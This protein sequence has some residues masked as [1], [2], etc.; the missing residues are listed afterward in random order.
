MPQDPDVRADDGADA[1]VDSV[2]EATEAPEEGSE[3]DAPTH[4]PELGTPGPPF[5]RSP[6]LI[7]FFGALGAFVAWW[8]GSLVLSIG[9]TLVLLVVAMFLAAGLN[10]AVEALEKRHVKRGLAVL[11]VIV[12]VLVAFTGFAFALVPVITDQVTAIG[13][14]VPGWVDQLESNDRIREIND[15]F[16]ILTKVQ[17]FVTGGSF[18]SSIFGGVLGVGIAIFSALA[19]VF[20]VVVLTLYFLASMRATKHAL[21]QLAPASRRDRVSRLGDKVLASVGGYVAG[22]FVVATCAGLSSLIF[23]FVVGLSEYAFALAFVVALLDVIPMVGATLGAVVVTLIG[24]AVD[25]TIG[26]ACLV[27]YLVYQQVENYFIYPRVMSRSVDVPGVVTVIA[28][29]VG[30]ALLGV[31]GALLAIPTASALLM[32][33]REVLIPR[34]DAR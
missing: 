27:F 9:S 16:D 31:V 10:P 25:P 17:D 33:A 2:S 19:N 15:Q 18:I 8:L 14:S 34:Q 20:F 12:G 4:D 1:L 6:F 24:F 23:F 28:A 13:Q 30:A 7:G 11:L 22:A 5:R 29:L 21:Y 32:L 26:L 3:A